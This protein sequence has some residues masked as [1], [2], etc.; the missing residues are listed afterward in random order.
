MLHGNAVVKHD[1]LDVK[2]LHLNP[3]SGSFKHNIPQSLSL[4]QWEGE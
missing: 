1:S 4:L 3:S 2:V